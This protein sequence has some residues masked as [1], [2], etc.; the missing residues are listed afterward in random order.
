MALTAIANDLNPEELPLV[1]D[2]MPGRGTVKNYVEN[3]IEYLQPKF[4]AHVKNHLLKN[5]GSIS[6]DFGTYESL[7]YI[8]TCHFISD[9]W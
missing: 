3:F 9:D 5:K 4:D 6:M 1:S 2:Y 8:S 7:Y